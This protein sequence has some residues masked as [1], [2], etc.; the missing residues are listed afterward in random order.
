MAQLKNPH[1]GEILKYE[2]LEEIGISQDYLSYILCVASKRIRSTIIGLRSIS[3]YNDLR[4]Y[5]IFSLSTRC[6]I[7]LQNLH[8]TLAAKRTIK[9]KIAHIVPYRVFGMKS[10]KL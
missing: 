7:R 2:F 10:N 9:S 1:S 5:R 8:D 4:L 3:S 6:F